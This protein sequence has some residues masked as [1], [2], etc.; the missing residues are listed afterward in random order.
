MS[1]ANTPE[2]NS[3][4][5]SGVPSDVQPDARQEGTATVKTVAISVFKAKCL[6]LID[7]VN[8][9]GQPLRITRRGKVLA[10]VV[11]VVTA[12]KPESWLGRMRGTMEIVGDIM[13]P[14]SNLVEW[15][16]LRD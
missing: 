5:H 14:S 4:T 7:E 15:E 8:K 2:V 9:T 6:A 10:E 1:F 16:A 12:P 13:E 11:P 3:D